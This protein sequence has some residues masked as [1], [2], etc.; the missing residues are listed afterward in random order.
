M[1]ATQDP[2]YYRMSPNMSETISERQGGQS[3]EG[4]KKRKRKIKRERE[5][6]RE[7]RQQER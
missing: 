1:G 2:K 6:E 5:M 3:G 4:R 7:E